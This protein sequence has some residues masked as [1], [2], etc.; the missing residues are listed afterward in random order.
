MAV[1]FFYLRISKGDDHPSKGKSITSRI[2]ELDLAGAAAFFPA[3]ILLLLALEW[4]GTTY[5]WNSSIIIGLFVGAGIA[6][7]L[8]I[9][10]EIWKGDKGLLP[11]PFFKQR[12]PLCSMLYAF[13][14]GMFFFPIV[15]YLGEW[16]SSTTSAKHQSLTSNS[17]ILPGRQR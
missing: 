4:G 15:Y 17:N 2:L 3:T 11:V 9:G 5:A 1:I 10:I 13:F 8:F 12:D 6:I 7:I 16:L 14:V